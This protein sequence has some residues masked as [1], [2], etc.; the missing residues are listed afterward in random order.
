MREHHHGLVRRHGGRQN[1][2]RVGV[3]AV[4]LLDQVHG[5]G[6]GVDPDVA[7][8]GGQAVGEQRLGVGP[9]TPDVEG[10]VGTEAVVEQPVQRR[11]GVGR[12]RRER[13]PLRAGHVGHQHPLGPGVVDGGHAGGQSADSAADCEQLQRVDELLDLARAMHAVRREERLP[14]GVLAGDRP[15]VRGH[16]RPA[17]R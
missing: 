14:R 4:V 2:T 13:Q 3:V 10:V 8:H 5:E 1:G 12:E 17:G 16:H 9:P 15:R 11:H 6:D 7:G